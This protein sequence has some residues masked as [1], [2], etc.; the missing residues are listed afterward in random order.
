MLG[1]AAFAGGQ[2]NAQQPTAPQASPLDVVPDKMPF[3][4]PYGPPISAQRAQAAI[5]AAVAEATK[6]DWP[7]NIAIV[8]SGANLVAFLR[9]DGAL[10]A[11]IAV[12]EHKARTAAKFRRPTK[13]LED[14][15]Q[16][17]DYKF[18]LSVDDV[19][20]A[21][22]GIPLIEDGKVIGAIGCSG[23]AGSQDEVVCIAGAGTINK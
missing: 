23:G 7:M 4:T 20:A 13:A 17:S 16:K 10:L 22:G 8:D 11:S 3:Y 12:A 15:V 14:A 5:Q 1:A 9:M 2:P 21:R 6:H 19:I 18:V